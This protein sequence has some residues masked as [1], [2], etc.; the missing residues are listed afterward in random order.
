MVKILQEIFQEI[1]QEIES[2]C[3]RMTVAVKILSNRR[4]ADYLLT[5][6]SIKPNCSSSGADS[7]KKIENF[8]A[9]AAIWRNGQESTES[10]SEQLSSL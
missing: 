2:L 7:L 1:P 8:E 3:W 6:K 4:S 5:F 9:I 10:L